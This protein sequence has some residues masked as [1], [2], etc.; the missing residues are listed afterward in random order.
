M[1]DFLSVDMKGK[2]ILSVKLP[3]LND[4]QVYGIYRTVPRHQVRVITQFI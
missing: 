2:V 1:D 3:A 4:K